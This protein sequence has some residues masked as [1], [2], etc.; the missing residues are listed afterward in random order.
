M[1]ALQYVLGGVLVVAAIFLVVV[2]ILQD[3][4]KSGL[5]GAIAGGSSSYGQGNARNASKRGTFLPKLTT[6]VSIA[7]VVLVAV[8]YL[9]T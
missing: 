1:T 2:V 6:A 3:K 8:S 4:K 5:S 9:F 7:F